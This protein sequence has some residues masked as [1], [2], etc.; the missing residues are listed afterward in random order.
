VKGKERQRSLIPGS[1]QPRRLAC[2]S[3]AAK[4][5]HVPEGAPYGA[6]ILN[7][8][9]GDEERLAGQAFDQLAQPVDLPAVDEHRIVGAFVVEEAVGELRQ[10]AGCDKRRGGFDRA[11][12]RP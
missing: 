5:W 1:D 3:R 7:E 11:P 2:A 10:L 9:V 12:P 4:R 6:Q 8:L